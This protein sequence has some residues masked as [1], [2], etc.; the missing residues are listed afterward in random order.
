MPLQGIFGRHFGTTLQL[1][2]DL[3]FMFRRTIDAPI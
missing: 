3:H 1:R 2:P